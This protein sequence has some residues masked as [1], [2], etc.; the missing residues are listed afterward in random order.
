MYKNSLRLRLLSGIL[1]ALILLCGA[2]AVGGLFS[3]SAAETESKLSSAY[4]NSF[5]YGKSEASFSQF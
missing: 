3:V 2:T 5:E 4:T 1:S